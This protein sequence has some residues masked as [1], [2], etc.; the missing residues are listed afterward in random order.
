MTILIDFSTELKRLRLE[1]GFSQESLSDAAEL[2]HTYISMLERG[3]RNP[4]LVTLHKIAKA[5]EMKTWEFMR[6]IETS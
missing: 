3:R 6:A 2:H 4:S 5:F 1:S